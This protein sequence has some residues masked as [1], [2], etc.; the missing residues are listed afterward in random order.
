M[1]QSGPLPFSSLDEGG[2]EFSGA[3]GLP[4][5]GLLAIGISVV[6]DELVDA[7]WLV[8]CIGVVI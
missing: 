3:L 4:V 1:P 5:V 7:G 8:R 6:D 2:G